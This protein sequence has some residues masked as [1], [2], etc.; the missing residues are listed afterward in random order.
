MTQFRTGR[1][2][3]NLDKFT[4]GETCDPRCLCHHKSESSEHYL[5]DC[6]LY[7]V[8]RQNLYNQ[9]EHYIPNFRKLTKKTKVLILTGG[10][11]TSDPEYYYTNVKISLAT[12]YFIA[13]TNSF[14]LCS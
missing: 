2:G 6:F 12:Q 10:I 11:N 3:L 8:E 14:S 4:L 7:T 1:T 13:K 9:F 5:L